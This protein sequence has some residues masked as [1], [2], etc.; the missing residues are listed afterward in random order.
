VTNTGKP[1]SDASCLQQIR[2]ATAEVRQIC[3]AR[4]LRRISLA[5]SATWKSRC[6]DVRRLTRVHSRLFETS[7]GG[8]T[9]LDGAPASRSS[10]RVKLAK[11]DRRRPFSPRRLRFGNS[12]IA[13]SAY[14]VIARICDGAE[15]YQWEYQLHYRAILFSKKRSLLSPQRFCGTGYLFLSKIKNVTKT[16][17]HVLKIGPLFSEFVGRY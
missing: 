14:G 16:Q 4:L 9:V 10:P 2:P 6:L 11:A 5:R 13:D 7:K 8:G 12:P 15:G 17:P 3:S 1:N